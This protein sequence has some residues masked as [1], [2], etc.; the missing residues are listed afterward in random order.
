MKFWESSFLWNIFRRSESSSVCMQ[1]AMLVYDITIVC[2]SHGYSI[3]DNLGTITK[4]LTCHMQ[5]L[6]NNQL[7][8]AALCKNFWS[9]HFLM[10][11]CL[12]KIQSLFPLKNAWTSSISSLLLRNSE[13][14]LG[15][16]GILGIHILVL[17]LLLDTTWASKQGAI[18]FNG[19]QEPG[20]LLMHC[21]ATRARYLQMSRKGQQHFL[22]QRSPQKSQ[23]I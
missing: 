13:K 11:V 12:L 17:H 6:L 22:F 20:D 9:V 2:V 4:N 23:L 7:Y 19:H 10:W 16:L 5:S 14:I 1:L 21:L 15:I 18:L 3:N 8:Q